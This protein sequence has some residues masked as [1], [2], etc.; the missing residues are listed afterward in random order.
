MQHTTIKV[1][2]ALTLVFL[3]DMVRHGFNV[4]LQHVYIGKHGI[5]DA[6]QHIFR[7]GLAFNHNLIG[8]VDESVAQR[9]NAFDGF[10]VDEMTCDSEKCVHRMKSLGSTK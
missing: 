1:G 9:F 6:L 3:P 5:V 10:R 2:E 7:L 4:V 8:V